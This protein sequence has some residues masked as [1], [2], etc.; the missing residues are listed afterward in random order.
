MIEMICLFTG[1]I[2]HK[3]NS[4]EFKSHGKE[5]YYMLENESSSDEDDAPHSKEQNFYRVNSNPRMRYLAAPMIGL[6]EEHARHSKEAVEG[7]ELY[8]SGLNNIYRE[9]TEKMGGCNL[10][11]AMEFVRTAPAHTVQSRNPQ[12][13]LTGDRMAWRKSNSSPL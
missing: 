6:F 13:P 2:Q 9:Y 11:D 4:I 10:F 12:L 7:R 5:Y 1:I 3:V 8:S